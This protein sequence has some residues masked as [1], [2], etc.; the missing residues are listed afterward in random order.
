MNEHPD[1]QTD[2]QLLWIDKSYTFRDKYTNSYSLTTIAAAK[3][4][5]FIPMPAQPLVT[6]LG[7]VNRG[8]WEFEVCSHWENWCVTR[9]NSL[10]LL[11][12]FAICQRIKKICWHTYT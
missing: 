4:D 8:L 10:L 9:P 2:R 11:F 6:V 7:N 1:R 5:G 3:P 12:V